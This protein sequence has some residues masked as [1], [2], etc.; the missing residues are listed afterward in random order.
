MLTFG[1]TP[2]IDLQTWRVRIFGR[3]ERELTLDWGQ[4]NDLEQTSVDAEFHCVTQW[5]RLE[6]TWEGVSFARVAGLARPLTEAMSAMARAV[7]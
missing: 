7:G 5:S 4:L 3:V 1:G 6:N 2:E